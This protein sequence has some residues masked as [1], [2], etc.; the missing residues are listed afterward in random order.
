MRPE[1]A[2]VLCLILAG[3]NRPAPKLSEAKLQE[4]K[5][6]SPGITDDCL[7]KI[8]WGGIEAMP[9]AVDQCFVITKPRQWRGV[10]DAG[11]EWS[12]FF[13]AEAGGCPSKTGRGGIWLT[14]AEGAYSGPRLDGSYEIEFVG[15]RTMYPGHFGHL[16]MYDHEMIVDRMISIRKLPEPKK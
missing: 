4:I 11:F 14:F 9:D 16:G 8:R 13:P 3:C 15:R 1:I 2:I 7:D 12:D 6:D 5:A 10:W